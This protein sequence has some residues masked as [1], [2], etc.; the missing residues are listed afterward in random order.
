MGHGYALIRTDQH[1][2]WRGEQP[3]DDVVDLVVRL[4]G[5]DDVISEDSGG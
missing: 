2:A 3:P 1:V 5:D 4:C